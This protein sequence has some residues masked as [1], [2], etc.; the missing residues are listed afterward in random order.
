MGMN[1][2]GGPGVSAL[3]IRISQ[4]GWTDV[5]IYL[6]EPLHMPFSHAPAASA[7]RWMAPSQS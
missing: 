6:S 3:A 7:P 2:V 1:G 5:I 4:T